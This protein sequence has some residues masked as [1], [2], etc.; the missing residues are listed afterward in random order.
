MDYYSL[1]IIVVIT[2]ITN[3]LIQKELKAELAWL[4]DP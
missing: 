2:W 1:V 4:L 3:L